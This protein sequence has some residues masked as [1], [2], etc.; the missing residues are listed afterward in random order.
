MLERVT[1]ELLDQ[2]PEAHGFVR[3]RVHYLGLPGSPEG[4]TTTFLAF[5][6]DS[7]R[8]SYVVK[9]F[10][11]PR[12][13]DR[14]ANE[15]TI[16]RLLA[17]TPVAT[18]VPRILTAID[19]AGVWALVESY[20][21]G[22]PMRARMAGRAPERNDAER[23]LAA[24]FG[25]L[26]TFQR[27]TTGGDTVVVAA[28]DT[29]QTFAACAKFFVLNP[30][31]LG[32]LA[33]TD[34][35][36]RSSPIASTIRH[37]DFTR[38]NILVA[39]DRVGVVDWSDAHLSSLPLHDAFAFVTGYF[40]QLRPREGLA[41]FLEAFDTSF[42]SFNAFSALV[43]RNIRAHG[44]LL[45]VDRALIEP[46]FAAFLAERAV[47][48]YDQVRRSLA[49]GSLPRATLAFAAEIGADVERAPTAQYWIGFLRR[50]IARRSALVIGR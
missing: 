39:R 50:L 10:R 5:V 35:A 30:E 16:L 19:D 8:P 22:R 3:P 2:A 13:R 11:D 32:Y 27:V 33:A 43:A 34:D 26:A 1:R 29:T 37:G 46:L 18:S 42:L 25:W 44:E 21:T 4:R 49:S 9:V 31:E 47:F 28:G 15:A 23:N 36:L 45:G 40:L 14:A 24:A 20:V 12:D 38:H 17:N 7:A 48:E 6:G 41:G